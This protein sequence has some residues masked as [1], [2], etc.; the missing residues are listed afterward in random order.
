VPTRFI[1]CQDDHFFPAAFMRRLAR[2]RLGTVPDEVPGCHCVAL[3]HPRELGELLVSFLAR[4][5]GIA[6]E[7]PTGKPLGGT[8]AVGR[9]GWQRKGHG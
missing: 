3:S 5:P 8:I 4:K 1:L 9:R 6:G 7:I 2:E